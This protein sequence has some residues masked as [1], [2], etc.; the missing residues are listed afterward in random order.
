MRT[1]FVNIKPILIFFF[2]IIFI[3]LSISA[4]SSGY[5][6]GEFEV[7]VVSFIDE[8]RFSSI[9]ILPANNEIGRYSDVRVR[10]LDRNNNPIAGRN[11]VL[12]VDPGITNISFVQ[13]KVTNNDGY[14]FG[15]VFSSEIG[16]FTIRAKDLTFTNDI[17]ILAASN[18][19]VFAV[20]AP[21]MIEEPYYTKSKLNTVYWNHLGS[22]GY[23]Y[24]VEISKDPFFSTVLKTSD[25][26]NNK[27]YTFSN[28]DDSNLY[29]YR[30]IA[31]N[32]FGYTSVYS[33]IVFTIQDAIPPKI[34]M[35]KRPEL[36]KKDNRDIIEMSANITDNLA[37]KSVSTYCKQNNDLYVDCGYIEKNGIIY[38]FVI[39]FREIVIDLIKD[40]TITFCYVA[41][42]VSGNITKNCDFTIDIEEGFSYENAYFT[43]IEDILNSG[44]SIVNELNKSLVNNIEGSTKFILYFISTILILLMYLLLIIII[45]GS[46]HL[47]N[48]YLFFLFSQCKSMILPTKSKRKMIHIMDSVINNSVPFVR[49]NI[50]N[51]SHDLVIS[52]ITDYR[53]LIYG[54]LDTGKYRVDVKHPDYLFPSLIFAKGIK[55]GS[56]NT[57]Y[58]G[59]IFVGKRNPLDIL[60]PIDQ[61][62]VISEMI[63]GIR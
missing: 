28:L 49:V 8:D 40:K 37:L 25:W 19:Y 24:K 12:Y 54:E 60:I 2:S 27:Y 55:E 62:S 38:T 61:I 30:V 35:I 31:K 14:A 29:Y 16:V 43:Y 9:S 41:N 58:G 26:I 59:Y 3:N 56:S 48:N 1:A 5:V 13:P 20:P 10:I 44:F 53:G 15:K 18:F 45:T 21:T 50:Y 39:D 52:E 32:S 34:E 7:T 11:I 57:Y 46:I 63:L 22:G 6:L 51:S 17:N 4:V 33:N 36:L 42:D 23:T 47:I